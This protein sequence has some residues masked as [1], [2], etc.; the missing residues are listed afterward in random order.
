LYLASHCTGTNNVD[1]S[2]QKKKLVLVVGVALIEKGEQGSK[3]RVLLAQRPAGKASDMVC[4]DKCWDT[5]I[6]LLL[7]LGND[8][9]GKQQR[10]H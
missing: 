10:K 9:S 2:T 4:F 5:V 3:P 7:C 6:H 1:G 8:S